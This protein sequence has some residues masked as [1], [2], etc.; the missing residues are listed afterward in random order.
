MSRCGLGLFWLDR[1]WRGIYCTLG[2]DIWELYGVYHGHSAL[3]GDTGCIS[4]P[5]A[6]LH[7]LYIII[8]LKCKTLVS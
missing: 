7:A 4:P 8:L 6:S 2:G 5:A 1:P 3:K